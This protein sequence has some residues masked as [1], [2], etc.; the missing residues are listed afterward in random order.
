MNNTE[1]FFFVFFVVAPTASNEI[2]SGV[3]FFNNILC[4]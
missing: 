2:Q 4:V 1:R 3:L